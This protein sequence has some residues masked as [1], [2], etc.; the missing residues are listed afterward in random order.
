[1]PMKIVTYIGRSQSYNYKVKSNWI[2]KIISI[3]LIY[4]ILITL[5]PSLKLDYSHTQINNK[6]PE[7]LSLGDT[8]EPDDFESPIRKYFQIKK[9]IWTFDDYWI[10]FNDCPPHPGFD[11]LSQ[12][13][14]SY[15]GNVN[16]MCP[17]IPPWMDDALG[18]VLRNYSVVDEFSYYHSG[19]LQDHI[20]LSLEF[21][22][23]P[24]IYPQCHGWNHSANLGF[25]N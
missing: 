4:I 18:N 2:M 21:F 11:G 8:L 5:I 20:N 22:N 3:L 9:I 14:N 16:I 10:H 23:R 17:F 6:K 19:F 12:R 1:M 25:A 13:I 15:G 7:L 24:L